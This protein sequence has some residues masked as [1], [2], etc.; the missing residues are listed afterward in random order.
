MNS[1]YDPMLESDQLEELLETPAP[2]PPVVVVQYRN[3]GVPPWMIIAIIIVTLAGFGLYH[4]LVVERYRVQAAQDRSLIL[5]K[6]EA[7]RAA[8]PL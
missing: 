3:R 6:L 1:D 2:S 5:R 4:K 7:D 8:Q